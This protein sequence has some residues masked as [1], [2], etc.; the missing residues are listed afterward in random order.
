MRARAGWPRGGRHEAISLAAI[1][2]AGLLDPATDWLALHLVATH[3]GAARPFLPPFDAPLEPIDATLH[4]RDL[5]IE[6]ESMHLADARLAD[7]FWQAVETFG[8]WGIAFLEAA[9]RLA[10]ARRSEA[11]EMVSLA[12]PSSS[13]GAVR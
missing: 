9:F 11:E 13:T 4:G 2:A 7:R 3:H 5:A 1:E 10:D 6:V 12:T 8:P